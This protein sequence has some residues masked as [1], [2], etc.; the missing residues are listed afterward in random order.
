MDGANLFDVGMLPVVDNHCHPLELAPTLKSPEEWRRYFSEAV[1]DG[2]GNLVTVGTAYY[3]RLIS[4]MARFHGVDDDENAVLSARASYTPEE[5]ARRL[6]HDAAIEGVVVDLGYPPAGACFTREDFV[7]STGSAYGALLRVEL[8]F[9]QRIAEC[10]HYNELVERL[11]HDLSDLRGVGYVGLKSI[12]GYR[13][14]LNIERWSSDDV[15]GAFRAARDEVASTGAVRLGYKPLLDT[16]LHLALQQANEDELPVQ[17]HV[18]YGDHDVDLRHATP[19]LLRS[20][21]EDEAYRR[22]PI[23]LLHSCWPYFREGAFLA[24]VYHNVYLDVSYG[25]PFL[26]AVELRTVTRA[27]VGTA[28]FAKIMYSSDGA[29]VPEI[30]WMAAHDGRRLLSGVLNEMIS[31]GDLTVDQCHGVAEQ[32][33]RANAHVLYG[34]A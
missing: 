23:V 10:A 25:I 34:L 26:G 4:A 31:A 6:F 32:M 21:M 24:S 15:E 9:Q 22:L 33:L 8:L 16:L 1:D 17:F 19:L 29:R 30:F 14:G 3:R 12:A 18:G 13:T 27:I 28:P 11:R 7:E 2:E 20:L 5:L